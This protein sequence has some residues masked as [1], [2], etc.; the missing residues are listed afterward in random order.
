MKISRESTTVVLAIATFLMGLVACQ[1]QEGTA[2][3]GAAQKAGEQIDRATTQA[4]ENLNKAGEQVGKAMQ[5]AGE[6]GGEAAQ[7]A[8]EK[9]AG[10]SKDAEKSRQPQEAQQQPD[11]QKEE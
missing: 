1:R 10:A 2:E 3:K 6:K 5:K 7:K 11:A 4:G 9:M 8:G